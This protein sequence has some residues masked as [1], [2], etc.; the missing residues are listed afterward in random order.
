MLDGQRAVTIQ[1]AMTTAAT[2]VPTFAS[3]N[4]SLPSDSDHALDLVAML[5]HGC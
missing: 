2:S 4:D 1:F 5:L 3:F